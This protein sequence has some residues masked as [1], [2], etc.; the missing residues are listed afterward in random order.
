MTI[1]LFHLFAKP[2]RSAHANG[3]IPVS[4]PHYC[5]RFLNRKSYPFG[6]SQEIIFL[7][8]INCKLYNLHYK[9][10]VLKKI[11]KNLSYHSYYYVCLNDSIACHYVVIAKLFK[12]IKFITTA[13]E[14]DTVEINIFQ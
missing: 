14:S 10:S 1:F 7:N 11:T 13:P 6:E 5:Y 8:R 12:R 4:Q 9:V 2:I 3:Q